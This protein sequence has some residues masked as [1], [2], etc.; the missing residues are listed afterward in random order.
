[1]FVSYFVNVD[2]AEYHFGN[3]VCWL[4]VFCNCKGI[5][6]SPQR[7]VEPVE[8]LVS[9]L[10]PLLH[11][12]IHVV[13]MS[14]W[15]THSHCAKSGIVFKRVDSVEHP[16]WLYSMHNTVAANRAQLN[17]MGVDSR[18]SIAMYADY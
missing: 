9:V 12:C 17:L 11:Q 10:L 4:R 8:G 15:L 2:E 14:D 16:F 13:M 6:A 1:M 18:P 5:A 3:F 7:L